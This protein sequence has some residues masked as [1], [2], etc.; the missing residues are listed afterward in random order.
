MLANRT[1]MRWIVDGSLRFRFLVVA[2]AMAMMVVGTLL[3]PD[4]RVDAFPEFAP[5]QVVIQ[6]TCLGLSTTDVE[7]L[8]TI[9]LEQAVTGIK[10]LK[11]MRSKSGP[12][13]SAVQMIFSQGTDLFEARQL[14]QERLPNIQK[15]LPSWAGRPTMLPPVSATSRVMLVSMSSKDDWLIRLSMEAFWTIRAR[16]LQVPGVANLA[17]WGERP[18]VMSVQVD[19]TL[20]SAKHVTLDAV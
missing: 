18:A 6:T 3:M 5:P 16:V 7:S 8:V 2:A 12:K 14:V 9:P 13:L 15:T 17:I 4:M 1:L 11:Q 19:P 10:G 20:M